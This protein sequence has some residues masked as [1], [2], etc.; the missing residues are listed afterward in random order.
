MTRRYL[1]LVA[2]VLALAACARPQPGGVQPVPAPT[3]VEMTVTVPPTVT[4]VG[5][6]IPTSA[7]VVATLTPIP[8]PTPVEEWYI[9]AEDG[10]CRNAIYGHAPEGANDWCRFTHPYTISMCFS[11]YVEGVKNCD[12]W[13]YEAT[14]DRWDLGQKYDRENDRGTGTFGDCYE[15]QVESPDGQILTFGRVQINGWAWLTLHHPCR[16]NHN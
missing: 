8:S 16:G 6:P 14:R 11:P 2:L 7:E 9:V 5:T 13:E 1:A 12:F 4:E 15:I 10:D 3:T